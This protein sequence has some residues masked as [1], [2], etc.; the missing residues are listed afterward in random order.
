V[1][2][3]LAPKPVARHHR[4]RRWDDDV[5]EVL[6]TQYLEW[7]PTLVRN[8]YGKIPCEGFGNENLRYMKATNAT[9]RKKLYQV[10]NS[11]SPFKE[12]HDPNPAHRMHVSR[13]ESINLNMLKAAIALPTEE[14]FVMLSRLDACLRYVSDP[15]FLAS[16][17]RGAAD[18]YAGRRSEF[19]PAQASLLIAEGMAEPSS[20]DAIKRTAE[21]FLVGE[22]AKQRNRFIAWPRQL[23]DEIKQHYKCAVNLPTVWEIQAIMAA[24]THAVAFDLTRSFYQVDIA[25]EC[26]PYFGFCDSEGNAYVLTKMQMG[27]VPSGDHEPHHVPSS[28]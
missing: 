8:A 21:V 5:S 13:T 23:N 14:Q 4:G 24:G 18:L 25:P 2:E 3:A 27:C 9:L 7:A 19:T 26:R 16:V 15:Q 1:H 6:M 11:I 17:T 28:Y 22:P 10:L 12:F 20:P